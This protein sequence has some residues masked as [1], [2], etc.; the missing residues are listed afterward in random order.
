MVSL[1]SAEDTDKKQ[2][3]RVMRINTGR[4][5]SVKTRMEFFPMGN[6]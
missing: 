5:G 1:I 2:P 4:G 3:V 6:M